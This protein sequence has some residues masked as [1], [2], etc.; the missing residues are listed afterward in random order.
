MCMNRD[1]LDSKYKCKDTHLHP[2]VRIHY[3]NKLLYN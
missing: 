2:N 3:I 1:H